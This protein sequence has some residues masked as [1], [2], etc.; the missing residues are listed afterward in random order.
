M[1]IRIKSKEECLKI[2]KEEE[3][4]LLAE[5]LLL[6]WL[7]DNV[8]GKVYD[9]KFKEEDHSKSF[10]IK[11][12]EDSEW[13]VK[14]CFCDSEVDYVLRQDLKEKIEKFSEGLSSLRKTANQ[15]IDDNETSEKL[16]T[17][18]F[19]VRLM[20]ILADYLQDTSLD[21]DLNEYYDK[22]VSL[23]DELNY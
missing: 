11:D 18:A 3:P 14:P 15:I 19:A 10:V 2:A 1:K 6:D 22:I 4:T 9:A 21:S 8:F 12:E 7:P 13:Y 5:E 23:Y 20:D 17:L 16:K